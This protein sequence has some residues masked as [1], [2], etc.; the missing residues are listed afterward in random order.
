M[1][2]SHAM[3]ELERM[4]GPPEIKSRHYDYD[5]LSPWNRE[6]SPCGYARG[7]IVQVKRRP[8][9]THS[10]RLL[11]LADGKYGY[12]S[13]H[14]CGSQSVCVTFGPAESL[15]SCTFRMA[16]IEFAPPSPEREAAEKD[17][18]EDFLGAVAGL[19]RE[20]GTLDGQWS[21]ATR[22]LYNG[23]SVVVNSA[24]FH[25]SG[26]ISIVD[27]S[28]FVIELVH[29]TKLH[30]LPATYPEPSRLEIKVILTLLADF[31]NRL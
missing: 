19:T 15:R 2:S 30:R 7:T 17:L 23:K 6:D 16:D 29:A 3:S 18:E 9:E 27:S 10:D 22:A 24:D 13:S 8:G 5:F 4:L 31:A 1:S 20:R 26:L 21:Q 14:D 12:I 25:G 28:A 11:E